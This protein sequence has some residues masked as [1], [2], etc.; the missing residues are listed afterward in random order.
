MRIS[1]IVNISFKS[2]LD[3][4]NEIKK[5][6]SKKF[7]TGS[8]N[9]GADEFVPATPSNPIMIE[10][11]E[12]NQGEKGTKAALKTGGIAAGGAATGCGVKDLISQK[13]NSIGSLLH[14]D[15]EH[16]NSYNHSEDTDIDHIGDN[17]D[18]DDTDF[19]DDS[20]DFDNDGDDFDLDD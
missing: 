4:G 15:D 17:E 9:I 11:L 10:K 20:D 16:I 3:L 14:S 2:K 18:A 7:Q 6:L 12:I 13:E 1:P 8:S 5:A 19:G